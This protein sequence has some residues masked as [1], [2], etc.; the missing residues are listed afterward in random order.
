MVG[1]LVF[2]QISS[3]QGPERMVWSPGVIPDLIFFV[4][5]FRHVQSLSGP[6]ACCPTLHFPKLSPPQPVREAGPKDPQGEGL[7]VFYADLIIQNLCPVA[8]NYDT[9]A[10]LLRR[11]VLGS[12]ADS[13]CEGAASE[14]TA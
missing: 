5:R 10:E 11:P 6:L 13:L 3:A 12:S 1:P 2:F 7:R 8:T 4:G 14:F 9:V